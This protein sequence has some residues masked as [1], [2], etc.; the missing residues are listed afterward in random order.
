MASAY[1]GYAL[2]GVGIAIL[3]LTLLIGYGQYQTVESG[4]NSYQQQKVSG[5][6][7]TA[8]VGSALGNI[9][10]SANSSMYMIISV[11]LLFLFAN[12][13]YKVSFLGIKMLAR[14]EDKR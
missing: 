12:V 11:V 10:S 5:G 8:V 2:L 13:G 6:N 9:S 3:M 14:E 1:V 4:G 7:I